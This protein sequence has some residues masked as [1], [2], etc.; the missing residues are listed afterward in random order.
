MEAKEKA[1]IIN[2]DEILKPKHKLKDDK[3]KNNV[4]TFVANYDSFFKKELKTFFKKNDADLK[5]LIGD[6]RIVVAEKR[7]SNIS[8]L[9]FKIFNTKPPLTLTPLNTKPPLSTGLIYLEIQGNA[10]LFKF[11]NQNE[12]SGRKH[13]INTHSAVRFSVSGR[14]LGCCL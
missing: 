9:L 3:S 11:A 7:H 4:L 8:S 10:R 2:G 6:C 1:M 12:K 5:Q 14:L 13:H